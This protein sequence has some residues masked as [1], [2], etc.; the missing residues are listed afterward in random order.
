[1][2]IPGTKD[3][4]P[5][6]VFVDRVVV[7]QCSV[8]G[9][10]PQTQRDGKEGGEDVVGT[11]PPFPTRQ[12]NPFDP[13]LSDPDVCLRQ[14]SGPYWYWWLRGYTTGDGRLREGRGWVRGVST[15]GTRTRPGVPLVTRTVDRKRVGDADRAVEKALLTDERREG[16]GQGRTT[17]AGNRRAVT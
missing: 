8:G 14:R 15:V 1:M 6:E 16:G 2:S 5:V 13:D 3:T 10:R 12:G 11:P 9:S 7:S 17:E 4:G